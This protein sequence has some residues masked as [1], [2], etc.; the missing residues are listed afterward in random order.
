MISVVMP[1]FNA[2]SSLPTT[3]ASLAGQTHLDWE[4]VAIDDG[5]TDGSLTLLKAF[6]AEHPTRVS[7][8]EQDHQGRSSA[9]NA[10]LAR[11]RGEFIALLDA[12]DVW[13]TGKLEQQHT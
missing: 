4:L 13:L 6:A 11:V 5:S 3:L 8:I 1:V 12:D 2:E 7:V 9:R 10:G